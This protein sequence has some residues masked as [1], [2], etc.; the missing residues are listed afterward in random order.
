VA[1]R[2]SEGCNDMGIYAPYVWNRRVTLIRHGFAAPPSISGLRAALR[3]VGL[4]NAPAGA[5][6]GKVASRQNL[7]A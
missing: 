1:I 4:R 7:G 6:P 3:A 5:A 2:S